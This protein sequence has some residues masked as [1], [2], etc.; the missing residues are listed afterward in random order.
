V[1][2]EDPKDRAN[3]LANARA[4]EQASLD[5]GEDSVNARKPRFEQLQ[6]EAIAEANRQKAKPRPAS[7]ENNH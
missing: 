5:S 2:R 3:F 4:D 7:Q 1:C 6:Q